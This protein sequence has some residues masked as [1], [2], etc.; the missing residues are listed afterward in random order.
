MSGKPWEDFQ[1]SGL[2][3][4]QVVEPLV[5]KKESSSPWDDFK[6]PS[7]R[8]NNKQEDIPLSQVPGK[9]AANI[10][11]DLLNMSVGI[12]KT[13]IGA[14]KLLSRTVTG[15]NTPGDI[16]GAKMIGKAALS[17]PLGSGVFNKGEKAQIKSFAQMSDKAFLNKWGGYEQIKRTIAEHPAEVLSIVAPLLKGLGNASKMQKLATL[18]EW[19]DPMNAITKPLSLAGK[20]VGAARTLLN[21]ESSV[22]LRAAEGRGGELLKALENPEIHVPGSIP[23]A[24]QAASGTGI[25]GFA[26]LGAAA[27]DILPSV[28][29]DK[30]QAQ[31]AARLAEIGKISQ[32]P[33]AMKAAE[34]ARKAATSPLY[35]KVENSLAQG[36]EQFR[37]LMTRP[38][39]T[40]A[41]RD[42]KLSAE[43]TG[44]LFKIGEYV[45]E[46]TQTIK[47][48]GKPVEVTSIG[49]KGKPDN[50]QTVK[51]CGKPGEVT[52]PP[53]YEELPGYTVDRVK[54]AL[55]AQ[56][57]NY[58]NKTSGSLDVAKANEIRATRQ[59][60][61]DWA[62]N[63]I[64]EYK[65]A[66][67]THAAKSVPIN[68]MEVGKYLE[69]T[70]A[71][72]SGDT[73]K[74][75]YASYAKALKDAPK[76]IKK[77]TGESRYDKLEDVM[78]PEQ[79]TSLKNI[80]KDLHRGALTEDILKD[81]SSSQKNVLKE[82]IN[83]PNIPH[84]LSPIVTVANEIINR[85]GGG[86]SKSLAIKIATDMASTEKA[87]AA[88]KK[89]LNFEAKVAKQAAPFKKAMR[90][91]KKPGVAPASN[92]VQSF[93]ERQ[94]EL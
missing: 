54:K 59:E 70:V 39:M 11:P 30:A 56:I 10:L 73:F 50:V 88:L 23:T 82:S 66:R 55:D 22:Y 78:T 62:E 60:F 16:S 53:K 14:A 20:G 49:K 94:E 51:V 17:I 28:F 8:V 25:T 13:G 93:R 5:V 52:T 69:D 71:P 63:K 31:K 68:Q 40:T 15:Q 38:S 9:A 47:V 4:E 85:V 1:T 43:E 35:D 58:M 74:E 75:K 65:Q 89:A 83:L 42:A 3:T 80:E 45:P 92:A 18:G 79:L 44:R 81:V 12:A 27:E 26:G 46:S 84:L 21:P 72:L 86:I 41:L 87:A 37:N 34:N 33:E 7:S 24:A 48:G 77:S 76:T 67:E 32:T 6:S 19:I 36:D 64:P 61:L 29:R 90:G 2:K 91:L 57:N